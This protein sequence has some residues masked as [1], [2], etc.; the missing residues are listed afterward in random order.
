MGSICEID[1]VGISLGLDYLRQINDTLEA[2]EDKSA[3]AL[4]TPQTQVLLVQAL[5]YAEH[6]LSQLD[7][8]RIPEHIESLR[9]LLSTGNPVLR[10]VVY[11]SMKPLDGIVKHEIRC[12]KFFYLSRDMVTFLE[13]EAINHNIRNE[14]PKSVYDLEEAS[15]CHV[16]GRS[17]ACVYHCMCALENVFP[18]IA[19]K[20][21][22]WGVHYSLQT[23]FPE[24]WGRMLAG[25]D[26]AVKREAQLPRR[27]RDSEMHREISELVSYMRSLKV[28]WRDE[29]MHARGQ[30]NNTVAD[31]ILRQ[32]IALLDYLA[33]H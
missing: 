24:T 26:A 15:Y 4:V 32:T 8:T 10:Q 5:N 30:F 28:A 2:M 27:D 18:K 1:L 21:A 29:T 20:A 33:T 13:N 22:S 17:T 14:F 12:A 19:E 11:D 31:S 7:L 23:N 16:F 3:T 9:A 25:L 6:A